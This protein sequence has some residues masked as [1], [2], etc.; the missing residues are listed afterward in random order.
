M[1]VTSNAELEVTKQQVVT[2]KLE[3][4][5]L[6]KNYDELLQRNSNKD[7][8]E[9]ERHEVDLQ[10]NCLIWLFGVKHALKFF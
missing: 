5:K 9:Q 6:R 8:L 7:N 10:V 3:C 4:E 2:L 1:Q